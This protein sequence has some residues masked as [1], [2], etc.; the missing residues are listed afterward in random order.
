M[1]NKHFGAKAHFFELA[2]L[3]LCQ[4]LQKLLVLEDL[5]TLH[6]PLQAFML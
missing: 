6:L 4:R 2:L 5:L 3:F 1:A